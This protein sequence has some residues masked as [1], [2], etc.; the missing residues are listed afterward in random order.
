MNSIILL[1][2]LQALEDN[3]PDDLIFDTNPSSN[4]SN[5]LVDQQIHFIKTQQQQQQQNLNIKPVTATILNKPQQQTI[6]TN[7]INTSNQQQQQPQFKAIPSAA[8][9]TSVVVQQQ[10]QQ[11]YSN[12][13]LQMVANPNNNVNTTNNNRFNNNPSLFTSTSV[14]ISSTNTI[15]LPNINNQTTGAPT[16]VNRM[17]VIN[18]SIIQPPSQLPQQQ[19]QQQ[20][21][22][23]T[24]QN[25]LTTNTGN[26]QQQQQQQQRPP[27]ATPPPPPSTVQQQSNA[28][29]LLDLNNVRAPIRAPPNAPLNSTTTLQPQQQTILHPQQQQQQQ[30]QQQ[31]QAA[32]DP[33]KRKLIQQQLVLLLHA[34]K[35][36][37]RADNTNSIPCRVP[38]C[39]IMKSVLQ[40]MTQ[41]H[42]GRNCTVPHC[43]SSRQIIS[44]WKNCNRAE[45]P[46][47]KPLRNASDRRNSATA[48]VVNNN[49]NNN[50]MNSMTQFNPQN[51]GQMQTNLLNG[52]LFQQSQNSNQIIGASNN[53]ASTNGPL[54]L[55]QIQNQIQP[56]L[57]GSNSNNNS[58]LGSTTNPQQPTVSKSWHE[59]ITPEMRKHLVQKIAQTIIPTT[60][61]TEDTLKDKRMISLLEYASKTE[62][63]MY[64]QAK[65]QEE[66]FHL[67]A[68]RIYKIQKDLEDRRNA[69]KNQQ[70]P[71]MMNATTT[72][73]QQQLQNNNFYNPNNNSPFSN[74][75][76]INKYDP[77]F[78]SGNEAPPNKVAPFTTNPSSQQINSNFQ[79]SKLPIFVSLSFVV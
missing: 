36:Q 4:Q 11:N 67:L 78:L 50:N 70:Q 69:K 77:D 1:V 39:Q 41:C 37:S 52:D 76:N 8:T 16:G 5:M 19:Q 18:R 17:T 56:G 68:E 63:E 43:S 14:P 38:H 13:H 7:K 71:G 49:N 65:D 60:Q 21:Q 54:L 51:S 44:H 25:V 20:V 32:N 30:Q 33:E 74:I 66:Y 6:I 29:Q 31:T 10:Q 15:N 79:G 35:C 42:D 2:Q 9:T 12:N 46:V 64:E 22:N 53:I 75:R 26:I 28:Q 45:C 3:L 57:S 58:Q 40:H 61:T 24:L 73:Q 72:G 55:Q 59:K 47:C 34:H 48:A 27:L 62:F 23:S